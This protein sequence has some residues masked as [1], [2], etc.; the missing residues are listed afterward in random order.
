MKRSVHG[1]VAAAVVLALATIPV[2]AEEPAL[3]TDADKMMY[4]LGFALSQRL[5]GFELN[6]AELALV[7]AGMTDGTL[8]AEP[9]V[10]VDQYAGQ[11]DGFLRDR[12]T[13]IAEKQKSAGAEYVA[14]FAAEDGVVSSESGALYLELEAGSGESPLAADAVLVHYHGTFTDGKVFDSSKTKGEPVRFEMG[15]TVPCFRDGILRMQPGGKAKLVCPPD[16]AYGDRPP[17]GLP[18]GA[19]L[20]FEVELIEVYKK[21]AAPAESDAA[22]DP[23]AGHDH[24]DESEPHTP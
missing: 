9:K 8:Q 19:T 14:A 20:V 16:S 5:V 7:V 18:P 1:L 4:T 6:E 2:A 22:D 21:E 11:I 10:P 15:Q 12:M 17:P 23:H 24:G 13:A 3:E